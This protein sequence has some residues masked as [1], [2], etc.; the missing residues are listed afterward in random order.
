MNDED[1]I[2]I[3]Y[4]SVDK[5]TLINNTRLFR[6]RNFDEQSDKGIIRYSHQVPGIHGDYYNSEYM[7]RILAFNIFMEYDNIF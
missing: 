7:N 6:L 4:G 1:E 3:A 2:T 5:C